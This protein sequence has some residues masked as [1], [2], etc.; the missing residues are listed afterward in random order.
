MLF[1]LKKAGDQ[2]LERRGEKNFIRD[3]L[4]GHVKEKRQK[5]ITTA[6]KGEGDG[7]IGRSISPAKPKVRRGAMGERTTKS[8][9]T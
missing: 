4:G 3:V 1:F 6:K 5:S 9:G 7:G 8:E 2:G